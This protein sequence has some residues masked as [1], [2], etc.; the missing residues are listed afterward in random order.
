M[1]QQLLSWAYAL[2]T[3]EQ[4]FKEM[5]MHTCSQQHYSQQPKRGGDEPSVRHLMNGRI[6]CG[7]VYRLEQLSAIKRNEGVTRDPLWLKLKNLMLSERSPSRSTWFCVR[8]TSRPGCPAETECRLT[9]CQELGEEGTGS[10]SLT[11]MGIPFGVRRMFWKYVEVADVQL[12]KGTK[13]H[14]VI[15]SL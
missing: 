8:A 5:H 11:N 4:V 1:A 2:N 10:S 15:W 13:N 12:S 9:G 6:S 14:W 3:W 7:L